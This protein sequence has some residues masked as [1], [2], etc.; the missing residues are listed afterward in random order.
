MGIWDSVE[1]TDVLRTDSKTLNTLIRDCLIY[2]FLFSANV[3]AKH[4]MAPLVLVVVLEA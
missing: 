4:M 2:F 3:E 1:L